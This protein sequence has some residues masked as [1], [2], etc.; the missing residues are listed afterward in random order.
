MS[1][2][3]PD[4]ELIAH[5]RDELSEQD[6]RRIEAHLAACGECRDTREAFQALLA[7]LRAT[8]PP[9]VAWGRWQAELRGRLEMARS[10]PWWWRASTASP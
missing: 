8:P 4:V 10:D 9:D 2:P 6:R 5:L 1:G 3:H 7:D